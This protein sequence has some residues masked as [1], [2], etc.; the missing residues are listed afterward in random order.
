MKVIE[1]TFFFLLIFFACRQ[2]S[3]T[4]L[5]LPYQWKNVAITGGGFVDGIVFHPNEP[6]LRYARTDMGGAYRW[7]ENINSWIALTD[8]ISYE[9][10]N[11]M[12]IESI[13]L[14][15]NNPN[16]LY[17]ACG[18]YTSEQN[19]N[20]E[21][22]V[23]DNRGQSFTRIKV[24]FKMGGNEIGRGNG[25]R[26]AVDPQNGNIVY[27]GTRHAGLWRSFDAG[28][29]W[30]QVENFPNIEEAAPDSLS[31]RELRNWNWTSRGSGIVWVVF[32]NTKNEHNQSQKIF[33]GVSL[34]NRE[35]IFYSNDAGASWKPIPDQPTSYRPNHGVIDTNGILYISYGDTPGP[36]PMQNGAVWKYNT[37]TGEWTDITPDKPNPELGKTFGYAAVAVDAQNPNTIIASVFHR[38]YEFGRD[39]I[40][41]STDGGKTWK[42]ILASGAKFDYSTAPYTQHTPIHWLFDIEINPFNPNHAI[43][44]TG[45]GGFETYD[46]SNIEK[47]LP[48]NWSVYTKGIEE[49]VPLELCS[50][51]EGAHLITAI[52]DYAGFVHWNLDTVREGQYFTNPYFGNCDGIACAELKPE[53]LVRVGTASAHH[54]GSNIGYSSNYGKSWKPAAMPTSESKH[55]HIAVSANGKTW[56]WTPQNDSPYFTKNDGRSW[57]KIESLEKNARVVADKVNPDKFYAIDLYEGFLFTSTDGAKT[58]NKQGIALANG[59]AQKGSFRG[60]KR[61]GQ[62][63]IYA[64]PGFEN[65]LWLAAFDGLYFSENGQSFDIKPFVNEI[66]AFGFGMAAPQ[67]TYPSLYLV[68]TVNGQRGIFRS[69]NKAQSWR[70]INDDAHQWGLILHITGDPKKYGRVYL[71][72]HGRGAIYGD[73]M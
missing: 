55:G 33:V 42:P 50:P 29:N 18:T 28:M 38:A 24:P 13:A 14:D 22:L 19:P 66:H 46:L 64:T 10:Q 17:M 34:K 63:R 23:S 62:D 58:F 69:D 35:N 12:G 70:R 21:I 11:L 7:D 65:Q 72:T 59:L 73:P 8:W 16:K 30:H 6:N 61:G 60:D 40:Y 1:Y 36:Y 53:I 3:K 37:N 56:V 68:G 57:T 26:M 31:E 27:L 41:R 25:E 39:D 44:T 15:P 49:T 45:F 54:G 52:G 47:G 51:P 71:G 4:T 32:G 2:E 20:G 48:T 5:N 67:K 9:D 43:F